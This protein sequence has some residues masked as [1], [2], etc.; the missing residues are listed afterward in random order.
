MWV[1]CASD[2]TPETHVW[3]PALSEIVLK[4]EPVNP[5]HQAVD[6]VHASMPTAYEPNVDRLLGNYYQDMRLSK[7]HDSNGRLIGVEAH[8]APGVTNMTKALLSIAKIIDDC[9]YFGVP[10]FNAPSSVEGGDLEGFVQFMV[11][12]GCSS[13]VIDGLHYVYMPWSLAMAKG[14]K[15]RRIDIDRDEAI[16]NGFSWNGWT[17]DCDEVSRSNLTGSVAAAQAGIPLPSGFTW[18]TKDNQNVPMNLTDLVSLG[19]AMFEHVNSKYTEAW[20]RKA[21]LASATTFEEVDAA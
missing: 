13:V 15:A 10:S 11:D 19:G 8:I 21:V 9:V 2:V 16:N 17:W 12:R 4:Q 5:W 18:R 14:N 7:L 20:S 3:D 6:A 1:D